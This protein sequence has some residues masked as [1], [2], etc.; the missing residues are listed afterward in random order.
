MLAHVRQV[1]PL[2]AQ[3]IRAKEGTAFLG[4]LDSEMTADE[5]RQRR[6]QAAGDA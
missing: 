2:F 6:M 4:R 3:F 1:T 5:R